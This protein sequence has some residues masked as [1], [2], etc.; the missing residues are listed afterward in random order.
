MLLDI[1]QQGTVPTLV[2]DMVERAKEM[3]A[4]T[5]QIAGGNEVALLNNSLYKLYIYHPAIYSAF[6]TISRW[7]LNVT[8][9]KKK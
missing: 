3:F 1:K 2:A 4:T 6:N 7:I 8:H 5:N 9:P